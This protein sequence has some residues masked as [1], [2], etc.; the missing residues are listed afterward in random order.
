VEPSSPQHDETIVPVRPGLRPAP[1]AAAEPT[2]AAAPVARQLAR[3]LRMGAVAAL[4]T[5]AAAAVFWWLPSWVE[6]E[7][8]AT[9]TAAAD[10]AAAPEPVV[11]EP[12]VPTLTA[13]Q[14]AALEAE[15]QDLL[16][17]LLTR[18]AELTALNLEQW[19]PDDQRR[20][21]ELSEAGDTAFLANDFTAAVASYKD[22]KA[23]ADELVA[24]AA[25]TAETSLAAGEAAI[26]AGNAELALREL[27][28]VLVI[29]PDH[30]PATRARARAERLPEVLALVQRGDGEAER[31]E[32]QAALETY[33]EALA[34]DPDWSAAATGVAAANRALRGAEFERRMSAGFDRLA[35]EDF[36]AARSEFEAALVLRPGAAEA[37]D[38][39]VQAD[40]G[41]KLAEIALAEAR[42][43]AFERRE[44]WA[45]AVALYREALAG[46]STLLFAQTGLARA[47]VRAGLDAKL[48]NLI[49]N[50][51]LLFSDT[52]LADAGKLLEEAAAAEPQGPRIEGQISRLRELVSLASTPIAVELRSD[53]VTQVTL[54]RV[55][56]LG[57]FAAKQVELRPGTYTVIGSRD[58]YRDV[59]R[60]FTVRPGG[61][62]APIDVVCVEP[63]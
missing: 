30:G 24:R 27:D 17:E 36:A 40:Q 38:G 19:A 57:A 46:D 59:R 16:A 41:A 62:L 20:Y 60:T 9:R 54:Y 2:P 61:N 52:V 3:R 48:V 32:W 33:R 15:A 26:A 10:T 21:R 43:L 37:E 14:R 23:L 25:S 5:V 58:G 55:G 53:A 35:A 31:G 7:R 49:D 51:T 28:R 50:P 29:E 44:L 39:I 1:G 11:E 12:T 18:Q 45:Q 8:E 56:A 42:A 4:L 34:I 22:A 6:R 13:E 47:E 63:I